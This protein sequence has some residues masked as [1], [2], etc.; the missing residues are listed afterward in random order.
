MGKPDSTLKLMVLA[1]AR[2]DTRPATSDQ[3]FSL[4]AVLTQD[5]TADLEDMATHTAVTDTEV[6]ELMLTLTSQSEA[7]SSSLNT[8]ETTRDAVDS[9]PDSK[10]QR[11]ASTVMLRP[12]VHSTVQDTEVT[13]TEW[14]TAMPMLVPI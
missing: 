3:R 4:E 5:S 13:V 11:S 8:L 9:R 10:D 1:R 6:L 12:V 7:A 2:V 14:A